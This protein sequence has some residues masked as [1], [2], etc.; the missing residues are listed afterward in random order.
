MLSS[1]HLSGH[2]VNVHQRP[3]A[4]KHIVAQTLPGLAVGVT[5]IHS[6]DPLALCDLLLLRDGPLRISSVTVEPHQDLAVD[7]TAGPGAHFGKLWH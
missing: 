4:S 6:A 3:V 7:L 2:N 5:Q 1:P